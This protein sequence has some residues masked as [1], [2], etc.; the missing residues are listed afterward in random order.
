M[1]SSIVAIVFL[2]SVFLV[3]CL[4]AYRFFIK[5]LIV[6][7]SFFTSDKRHKYEKPTPLNTNL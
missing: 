1:I 7:Y 2:I 3:I 5:L 4:I 6:F